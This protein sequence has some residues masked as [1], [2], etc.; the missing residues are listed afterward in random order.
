MKKII[1]VLCIVLTLVTLLSLPVS[2]SSAYQTYT[3]SI[4]GKA[5][6]SPDAYSAYNAIDAAGMGL[7]EL[8]LNNA[9]D[10]V[11]DEDM[12]VYIADSGNNRIVAL[13]RYYRLKFYISTFINEQGIDEHEDR[14]SDKDHADNHLP[15]ACKLTVGTV[16]VKLSHDLLC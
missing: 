8:G 12:N 16:A 9:A 6:Y 2:A 14:I 7:D 1:S 3:Y 10:L 15:P 13:D 5:L 4:G 11:T